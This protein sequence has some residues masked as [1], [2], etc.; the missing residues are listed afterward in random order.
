MTVRLNKLFYNDPR[1]LDEIYSINLTRARI[2]S[3]I[4]LF[5]LIPLFLMD[6]NKLMN[7]E[8]HAQL[9]VYLMFL[10]RLITVAL[11]LLGIA[12]Y[13]YFRPT[14]G[15]RVPRRAR[16]LFNCIMSGILIAMVITTAADFLNGQGIAN[17]L[18]SLMVVSIIMYLTNMTA[19]I[20]YSL[21][22]FLTAAGILLFVESPLSR[23]NYLI[24][25][26]IYGGFAFAGSRYLFFLKRSEY[27]RSLENKQNEHFYR[28]IYDESPEP[29]FILNREQIL[30]CNLSAAT[31]LGFSSVDELMDCRLSS[32]LDPEWQGDGTLI[33]DRLMLA[34]QAAEV[35]DLRL[36]D[37][38][39]QTVQVQ[40]HPWPVT[41]NGEA[42]VIL[43]CRNLS[44]MHEQEKRAVLL[45]E[46]A[47]KHRSAVALMAFDRDVA[48]GN[49]EVAF[50]VLARIMT[51]AGD[52]DLGSIWLL[53]K[54]RTEMHCVAMFDAEKEELS[55]GAVLETRHY[56][57]YFQSL[58]KDPILA[59][60]NVLQSEEFSEFNESYHIPRG[61]RSAMDHS[62][63]QDGELIGVICMET[64]RR[65]RVWQPDD[66]AF[67]SIVAG[68]VGT[69][70]NNRRRQETETALEDSL[71]ISGIL[72]DILKKVNSSSGL[73]DLYQLVHSS[74]A[75]VV[76]A[77]NF[78]IALLD[79]DKK[80]IRLP[81]YRDEVDKYLEIESRDIILDIDDPL[82]LT[83]KLLREKETLLWTGDDITSYM[84][85]R[86]S[87]FYGTTP[88]QWLGVPVK[89][90]NQIIGCIVT[91]NYDDNVEYGVQ[92]K[93]FLE[94]VSD[95][96]APA[97]ERA[98]AEARLQESRQR[99]QDLFQR[100]GDPNLIIEDGV[101]ID[102]NQAALDILGMTDKE[103]LIGLSPD[104]ISPDIQPDGQSSV[105]KA[106][107][108]I[109]TALSLGSNRFEWEHVSLD[110]TAVPVEILLTPI[111]Y[112]GGINVIHTVWR[113]I[114][115][116][117]RAERALLESQRL[118]AIGEMASSVAHDFN[119]ALQSI[120]GN[121]EL[122]NMEQGLPDNVKTFLSG[123]KTAAD[124]AATRVQ[125]LQRFAGKK[126][127]VST[128][129]PVNLNEIVSDVIIQSRPLWK[130][131]AER[132][133]LKIEFSRVDGDIPPV[134]GNGGELRSVLYNIIKNSIEAMPEGGSINVET[135]HDGDMVLLTVCDEGTGMSEDIAER[136]FQ[137]LFSTKGFEA[138]RGFGMSGSYSIIREHGGQIRV[139]NTEVGKGTCIQ[140]TL[141]RAKAEA[142]VDQEVEAEE[143]QGRKL[144]LLWVEDDRAILDLGRRFLNLF[145][146]EG[147]FAENGIQALE[148]M[149]TKA[150]DLIISDIG[151]PEMNGWEL[152]KKIHER[153]GPDQKVVLLTGWAA[154]IDENEMADKN[155][156]AVLGKPVKLE[157]LKQLFAEI[158]SS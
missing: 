2:F 158:Q 141:P 12:V 29:M 95:T 67:A 122:A 32:I 51:E 138:G 88:N 150:Y 107:E 70:L 140:I 15:S 5:M 31:L 118:G 46:K 132:D 94:T 91:Q 81:Y 128:Y 84:R 153:Y 130:D 34:P 44:K 68:F 17:I 123:M 62:I 142:Q 157:Q 73:E 57:K 82:S 78:Y 100:S 49:T 127:A 56:R 76:P 43:S 66:E 48:Q 37:R 8:K 115:E 54:D 104:Q 75:A 42:A 113:D 52:A 1:F 71:K 93:H 9:P 35:L 133:G 106:E 89:I 149:E 53:N 28:H 14:E 135:E 124:D 19:V 69:V 38:N 116:K 61:I 36:S 45:R 3:Y 139:R 109:K 83:A 154:Q 11:A 72:N 147:D 22:I 47:L 137:P 101:F 126:E 120:M 102:C 24:N 20:L 4:I 108:M 134:L 27:Y 112:E 87:S 145:G 33:L 65:D 25:L 85:D 55:F 148:L 74:V 18:G 86:E 59:A 105:H 151:M 6:V 64:I 23:E 41:F 63:I 114:T 111:S 60:E 129:L 21:S 110:G 26:L 50:S 92:Q 30:R 40:A 146:H 79:G 136:I 10:S 144:R 16:V 125:L 98:I 97:F 152:S 39:G 7:I 117:R 99:Y 156:Y 96:I 143:Q 119:N 58:G 131:Q 90:Q 13:S 80:T 103:Q 77:R 121:L 155:I